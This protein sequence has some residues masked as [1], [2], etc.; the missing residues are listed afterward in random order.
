MAY[1]KLTLTAVSSIVFILLLYLSPVVTA[2]RTS[3]VIRPSRR[4]LRERQPQPIGARTR[5]NLRQLQE[6]SYDYGD[7]SGDSGGFSNYW[8]DWLN[9]AGD[10][11]SNLPDDWSTWL[12][13]G[14]DLSN[15]PDDWS[16]W[17]DNGGDL[18][19]LP[20]DWSSWLNN[21]G[22]LSNLPDDWSTWLNNG[23]DLS[24]LPDDWSTWLNNGGDLSNLPDDWSTWLNNGADWSNLPDD[25]WTDL[26]G[27]T[28]GGWDDGS[29]GGGGS[30][31]GGGWDYGS[32]DGSS[33]GGGS[34]DYGGSSGEGGDSGGNGGSGGSEGSSGGSDGSDGSS[35]GNG[36]SDG[37]SGGSDGSSGG[38]GGNGGGGGTVDA[39]AMLEGHNA[40]R[41]ELGL[42]ALGWDANLATSAQA[43][44][45]NL[46]SRG[47]PMEHGGHDNMGQNL[48][49]KRPAAFNA[50]D[51]RE[52]VYW[53]VDE[54]NYWTYSPIPGGCAEGQQCLHYTQIV[55]QDTTNVGCAAAQCGDGGGMWVCHY[56]P[57]GNWQGEYPYTT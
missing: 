15:F 50:D 56:Y 26:G 37:S 17:L 5:G 29:S 1:S 2:I 55:W 53:W 45:D 6:S 39:G 35:G 38:D 24:N 49:W 25:W 44:A 21:G 52:A 51:D 40:A 20:D 3:K 31:D 30:S 46:A 34:W 57:Q 7:W 16:T 32:T 54:K 23:G 33:D 47:C 12:N 36:G 8:S 42:P 14:G 27:D 22:D 10:W 11:S 9:N 41:A 19:N 48:Y 43:W 13:N 18:S 4:F 28:G